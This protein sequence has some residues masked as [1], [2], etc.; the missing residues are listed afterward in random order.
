VKSF[1]RS[2]I[3]AASCWS[4]DGVVMHAAGCCW[5]DDGVVMHAD[6]RCW[7]DDGVLMHAA[8]S[9]WSGD[10][11]V[12]HHKRC[13]VNALKCFVGV[14]RSFTECYTVFFCPSP[15]FALMFIFLLLLLFGP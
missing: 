5:S 6:K 14:M 2:A 9:C 4:G 8:A 7:S 10:G 1:C 13:Y 15:A 3:Q 11:V 12:M